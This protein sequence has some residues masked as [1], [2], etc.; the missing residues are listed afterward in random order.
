M[1]TNQRTKKAGADPRGGREGY[2]LRCSFLLPKN[3]GNSPTLPQV[4]LSAS[5]DAGPSRT[6]SPEQTIMTTTVY[7]AAFVAA[8]VSD[9]G[10]RHGESTS[11]Q[12]WGEAID[13]LE[14]GTPE[15]HP[16]NASF[17]E[18]VKHCLQRLDRLEVA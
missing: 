4:L 14:P 7:L 9:A 16:A 10:Q 6:R 11:A 18:W 2:E 13:L 8:T 12:Y 3:G 1:R 15:E 5:I 17:F